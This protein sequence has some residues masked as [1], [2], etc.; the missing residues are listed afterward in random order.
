MSVFS[1]AKKLGPDGDG[2]ERARP[3]AELGLIGLEMFPCP[4]WVAL[5]KGTENE[6]LG[7]VGSPRKTTLGGRPNCEL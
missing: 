5:G 7:K 2:K 4:K 6:N 1:R 3:A